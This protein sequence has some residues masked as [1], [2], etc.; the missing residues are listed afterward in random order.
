MSYWFAGFGGG[1]ASPGFSKFDPENAY[2]GEP[3]LDLPWLLFFKLSDLRTPGPASTL[4]FWDER[5]DTISTGNFW[6]DMTGFPNNPGG[7]QFNWDYPAFYHNGAGELTFAD[8]H[9]ENH[10]WLDSR[11]TPPYHDSNWTYEDVIPSGNNKDLLWLQFR[12]TRADKGL[13]EY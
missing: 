12:T 2:A 7:I 5:Y 3:G 1:Y 13:G 9:A 8:G 6:I 11:T 4:L 10:K